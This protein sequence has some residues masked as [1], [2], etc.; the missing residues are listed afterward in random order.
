MSSSSRA[1]EVAETGLPVPFSRVDQDGFVLIDDVLQGFLSLEPDADGLAAVWWLSLS[2]AVVELNPLTGE[3]RD[4]LLLPG[5]IAG[6]VCDACDIVDDPEICG[7]LDEAEC[8]DDNPCTDDF[9]ERGVCLNEDNDDPCDDGD[10]CTTDDTC[11][12]GFCVG[13]PLDDCE[14]SDNDNDNSS[15]NDNGNENS[16]DDDGSSGGSGGGL[17]SLCGLGS[18]AAIFWTFAGLMATGLIRRRRSCPI[19]A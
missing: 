6:S 5:D 9:C 17:L 12:R 14:P 15:D 11:E 13:E 16:S 3:V 7:C 8:D 10:P 2:G 4:T 1:L 18:A 19:A